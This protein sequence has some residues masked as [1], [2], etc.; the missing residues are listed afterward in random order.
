[1]AEYYANFD[2]ATGDN[3][4]TDADNAW[5][6]F[7][8]AI[9]GTNGTQPAEGDTV[10]CLG[11]D[12]IST[13]VTMD[14]NSGSVTTGYVK[15]IGVSS[16]SPV[17]NNGTKAIIDANSTAVNCVNTASANYI[18]IE[19]FEF[20]GATADGWL[21]S[22]GG[23]N[24]VFNNVDFDNN[25]AEGYDDNDQS[26]NN[27]FFF[28]RFFLNTSDGVFRS[29][30]S[31]HAWCSAYN[32]GDNGFH[33]DS[34]DRA[35]LIYCL[36]FDNGDSDSNITGDAYLFVLSCVVD[37]TGQTGET[38]IAPD[39]DSVVLATRIT[40]LATGYDGGTDNQISAYNLFHNNTTDINGAYVQQLNYNGVDTNK[41]DPDADDGYNDASSDDY[42]L[43]ADRTFIGNG[44]DVVPLG[45]GDD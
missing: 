4:G 14:G 25:G 13:S 45:V 37:G 19:N 27:R 5:Q 38:G 12:T 22:S 21:G 32:N 23:D 44:S 18:W 2:L 20:T 16:L 11:T 39:N 1:M 42:N 10:W 9:D 40:N 24:L 31:L 35:I 41:F 33:I 8:D 26:D 28:C 29:A 15:F 6:T 34:G 30:N 17:M 36:A 43:K 3:D 7:Q